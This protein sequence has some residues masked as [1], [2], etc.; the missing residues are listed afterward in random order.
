M[1]GGWA[2][3]SRIWKLPEDVRKGKIG[4]VMCG[5]LAISSSL[6]FARALPCLALLLREALDFV[7]TFFR[8][9]PGS[10]PFL[11]LSL[12]FKQAQPAFSRSPSSPAA[13]VSWASWEMV[14]QASEEH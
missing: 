3:N 9:W 8:R 11:S 2:G 4:Q 5:A 1:E 10:R 14:S 7:A 6:S 13:G 12:R